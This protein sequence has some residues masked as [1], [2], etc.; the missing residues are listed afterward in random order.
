MTSYF[1]ASQLVPFGVDHIAAIGTTVLLSVLLSVLV[2]NSRSTHQQRI[3][4][5]GIALF[6]VVSECINYL[7][8][9]RHSGWTTFVHDALPLHLCGVTLYLTAY[10]LVTK[11]Q[12]TFELVYFWCFSGTV[13][14][15]LTPEAQVGFPA[16]SC[17]HFFFAHGGTIAGVSAMTF[18][19][20]MRP[21]FKGMW[22]A[23]GC[24]WALF[25]VVGLLDAMLNADY[26]Y[27]WEP[28]T[29]QTPFYFLRWPWY[30]PFLGLVALVFCILLWLPFSRRAN[31][32]ANISTH[33]TEGGPGNSI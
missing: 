19:L 30:I 20:R 21:R 9:L 22:L 29:G 11:R 3:I 18:G 25:L 10:T 26:M 2:R 1:I 8:V 15:I 12:T 28:P 5:I 6:L 31:R 14:A 4:C 27:F 24:L 17:F 13:Q 7:Y 33:D 23:Y 32:I 16:W